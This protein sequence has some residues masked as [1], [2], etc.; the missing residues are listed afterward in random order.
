MKIK[1]RQ[2][3]VTLPEVL[4]DR[5]ERQAKQELQHRNAIMTKIVNQYY[6]K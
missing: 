4:V 2:I 6:N 1:R 5:I 3:T